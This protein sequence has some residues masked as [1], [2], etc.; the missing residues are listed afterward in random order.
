MFKNKFPYGK[1]ALAFVAG[2]VA[3]AAVVVFA[4]PKKVQKQIKDAVEEQVDNVERLVK[5]VVNA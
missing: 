1:I 3:G 4:T 2:F 5:K